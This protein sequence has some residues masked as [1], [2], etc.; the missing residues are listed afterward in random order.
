L[1]VGVGGPKLCMLGASK[2]E[3][4]GMGIPICIGMEID[5]S[6]FRLE[7]LFVGVQSHDTA[8][9]A[10]FIGE[11]VGTYKTLYELGLLDDDEAQV[12][13]DRMVGVVSLFEMNAFGKRNNV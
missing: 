2:N 12:Y 8:V 7:E 5:A 6:L 3:R 4:N 9:F 10:T 13:A 11:I 1:V